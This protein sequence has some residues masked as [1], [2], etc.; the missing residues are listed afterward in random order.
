MSATKI[1]ENLS[2][3]FIETP[4]ECPYGLPCVALYRQGYFGSLPP[5][6]VDLFFAAGFRRNGN[7]LYSMQCPT[8]DACV[9]IRLRSKEFQP[10]RNLKR[11]W[12]KNKDIEV[13]VAPLEVSEEKYA[14][15]D[16]FL[17]QRYPIH[18][19]RAQDYYSGFFIN[20]MTRTMEV[21]YYI[22]GR[23]VGVSIVDVLAESL[24]AVY[25]YFDP[26][27]S[28]RSL[29]TYNILYLLDWAKNSGLEFVY[30]GYWI[31]TVD[32][33]Q[34]KSRFKPHYLLQNGKWQRVD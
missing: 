14:L 20:S 21:S 18:S 6:F 17:T 32:A 23:L 12:T 34:Y 22:K 33:M 29:G 19:S 24:S 25:F 8:C 28:K 15:L 3:Y 10:S 26:D 4:A 1:I 5:E 9:P 27:F 31:A 16:K 7:I 11:V 30:L 2:Q 13:L